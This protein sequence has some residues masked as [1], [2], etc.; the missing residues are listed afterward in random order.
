[1]PFLETFDSAKTTRKALNE[2]TNYKKK[3]AG[4]KANRLIYLE[5]TSKMQNIKAF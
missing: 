3:D 2:K 1:V 4:N 5:E